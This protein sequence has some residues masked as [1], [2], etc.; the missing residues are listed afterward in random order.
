MEDE[1]VVGEAKPDDSSDSDPGDVYGISASPAVDRA[2]DVEALRRQIRREERARAI[3][4]QAA[5]SGRKHPKKRKRMASEVLKKPAWFKMVSFF[6]SDAKSIMKINQEDVVLSGWVPP[7]ND[8]A[9]CLVPS[10]VTHEQGLA[11][12][13]I[14]E[15]QTRKP[16][17]ILT[18]NVQLVRLKPISDAQAAKCIGG[19]AH[20]EVVQ[21]EAGSTGS[22]S[23]DD[24][25]ADGGEL[26]EGDLRYT[27]ATVGDGCG[28]EGEGSERASSAADDEQSPSE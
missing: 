16:V 9:V 27:G 11:L 10:S 23:G 15:G 21:V 28:L 13:R 24:L 2:I 1:A 6:D 18:N 4:E 26:D 3:R 17:L 14:I 19:Q 5:I 8:C 20:G 25:R 12:Q 7:D 22:V